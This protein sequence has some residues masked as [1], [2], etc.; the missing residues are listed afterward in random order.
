MNLVVSPR[1]TNI[2]Q[3]TLDLIESTGGAVHRFDPVT[4]ELTA[5]N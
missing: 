5:Y 3:Q 1:T 2:S 4:G